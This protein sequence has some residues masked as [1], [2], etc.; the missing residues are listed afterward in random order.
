L[1]LPHEVALSGPLSL[2]SCCRDDVSYD[3]SSKTLAVVS[4]IQKNR[5]YSESRLCRERSI[6]CSM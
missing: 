6:E 2:T 1:R 5:T 4:G 3:V